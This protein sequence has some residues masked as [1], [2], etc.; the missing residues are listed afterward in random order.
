MVLN[1]EK[2]KLLNRWRDDLIDLTRNNTSLHLPTKGRGSGIVIAQ[3]S[4]PAIIDRLTN[5]RSKDWQFF[6]PPMSTHDDLTKNNQR[7]AALT[8]H[9]RDTSQT[10]LTEIF[11]DIQF[12]QIKKP[13]NYELITTIENPNR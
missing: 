13:A 5:P 7:G 9:E 6:H 1:H 8:Q 3:P 4:I 10:L 11:K 12:P 2:E